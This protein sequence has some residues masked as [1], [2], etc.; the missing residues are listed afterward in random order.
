[1]AL[2]KKQPDILPLP[3]EKGARGNVTSITSTPNQICPLHK[4]QLQTSPAGSKYC[5][6][7]AQN[8]IREDRINKIQADSAN[9]AKKFG[10]K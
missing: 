1:M 9:V 2:R 8:S 10:P 7:C 6:K 4:F 3:D 5:P